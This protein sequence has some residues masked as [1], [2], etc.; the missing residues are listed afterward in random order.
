MTRLLAAMYVAVASALVAG[1]PVAAQ[2][3]PA[4]PLALAEELRSLGRFDACAVEALRHAYQ[5]PAD[6]PA[7]FALAARCL[8]RSGRAAAARRLLEDPRARDAQGH[9]PAASLAQL[10]LA[11][12][13]QAPTPLPAA[14]TAQDASAAEDPETAA[15]LALASYAPVLHAAWGSDWS[16]VEARVA[17][18]PRPLHA[19][20]D[21]WAREDLQRAA[22]AREL[23]YHHAWL[24]GTLSAIVPGLG[25]VYVGRWQDGL[26]TLPLVGVPAYFAWSGFDRN[27]TSS[28]RGWLT[29]TLAGVL[30]LGNVYGSAVGASVENDRV[31]AEFREEVRRALA[32]RLD[33]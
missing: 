29:G 27:G 26:M 28:V 20:V 18:L 21:A 8:S 6:G 10:C 16:A 5:T 1:G 4:T 14:C 11:A 9:L 15:A 7:A 31:Q 2:S 30:Y 17:A 25:R 22:R 33:R 32:E 3:S 24:A 13:A 12:V 23:P 19:T